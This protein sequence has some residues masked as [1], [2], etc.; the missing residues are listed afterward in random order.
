MPRA[1]MSAGESGRSIADI[2]EHVGWSKWMY[3]DYAFGSAAM[4]GDQPLLI[5]AD[6]ARSRPHRARGPGDVAEEREIKDQPAP[7]K[8]HGELAHANEGEKQPFAEQ[9][10]RLALGHH[11]Q[12]RCRD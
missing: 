1:S 7:E 8:H 4:R 5:P 9:Q 3:E 6:G 12:Q 11:Q 10:L 2:L